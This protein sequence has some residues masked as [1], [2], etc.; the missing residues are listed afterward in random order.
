MFGSYSAADSG[1]KSN[2]VTFGLPQTNLILRVV[3][4]LFIQFNPVIEKWGAQKTGFVE[5]AQYLHA[6]LPVY[7]KTVS[8]LGSKAKW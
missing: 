3:K 7:Y 8:P 6:Q 5:A 2:F 4:Q 1:L